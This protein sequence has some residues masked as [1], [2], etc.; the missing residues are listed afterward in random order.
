MGSGSECS[1]HESVED[2]D[3]GTNVSAFKMLEDHD[4]S[5][6]NGY[7]AVEDDCFSVIEEK[8]SDILGSV[9]LPSLE[10]KHEVSSTP[11][12]TKK[13][14]WMKKWKRVE[15]DVNAKGDGSVDAGKMVKHDFLSPDA[16]TS[17][18][19]QGCVGTKQ[20]S[21]GPVSSTCKEDG[22][23]DHDSLVESIFAL[24]SVQEALEK[25][26]LKVREII[27]DASN[28]DSVR[29]LLPEFEDVSQKL[30]QTTLER[31]QHDEG[32][33][34]YL[35]KQK[36]EAE[37][38]YLVFSRM[39]QRLRVDVVDQNLILGHHKAVAYEQSQM[40]VKLQ[41]TE[42]KAKMIKK[43]AE[44][45]ENCCKDIASPNDSLTLQYGIFKYTLCFFTGL[46]LL[47]VIIGVFMFQSL[48]YYVYDVP[49]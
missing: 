28:D 27:H 9:N 42:Y 33:L 34:E 46:V 8:G 48:P 30:Q 13:G 29:N 31:S 38:E 23:E 15:R 37:V 7:C 39:G 20:K 45:L 40:L 24:Q 47:V 11:S 36:I 49:T 6:N 2:N 22:S 19:L 44:K 10:S 26:L 41:D 17:K 18:R 3:S 16:N 14:V 5:K 4:G 21:E 32:E 35:F 43:E 25:E 1:L 12:M